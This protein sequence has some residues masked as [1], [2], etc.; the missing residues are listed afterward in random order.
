[1]VIAIDGKWIWDSWYAKDGDT[2]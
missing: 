2:Y 1:M